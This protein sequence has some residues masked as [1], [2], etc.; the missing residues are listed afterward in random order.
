MMSYF[1]RIDSVIR[2]SVYLA[3]SLAAPISFG[4]AADRQ[5]VQ[6]RLIDHAELLCANCFFGPTDYYFCFATDQ[7]V[8]IGYQRVPV[9]NWEDSSKNFLTRVHHQWMPWSAPGETIP[10]GY[11]D[12]HIW[13]ARVNGKQVKLTRDERRGLF[14][15]DSRCG[16]TVVPKGQ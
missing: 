11:D 1:S 6:A 2:T 5:Q 7:K 4:A 14:T 9:I 16:S 15:H 13:V 10:L 12:K 8:L 3:C